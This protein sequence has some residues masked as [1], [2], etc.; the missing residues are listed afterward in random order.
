M[1]TATPAFKV[2]SLRLSALLAG[3]VIVA[4]AMTPLWQAAAAI[5]G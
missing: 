4:S 2:A 3:L 5:S 1:N